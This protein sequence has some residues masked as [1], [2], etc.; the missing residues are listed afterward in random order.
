[1]SQSYFISD[2]SLKELL[3]STL[4]DYIELINLSDISNLHKNRFEKDPRLPDEDYLEISLD[5]LIQQ[6]MFNSIKK[7][8]TY[9]GKFHRNYINLIN[10]MFKIWINVWHDIT[11]KEKLGTVRRYNW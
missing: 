11:A 7:R 6:H 9:I 10:G 5:D 3:I 4:N 2:E 8:D 1:M